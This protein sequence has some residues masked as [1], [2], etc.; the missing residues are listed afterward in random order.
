MPSTSSF[1]RAP[2]DLPESPATQFVLREARRLHRA[3]A[4]QAAFE[5]LPVL[6]RLLA[7]GAAPPAARTLTELFRM[8]GTLQRKHVLR[9]LA[10]EAGHASWEQYRQVLPQLDV[11]ALRQ[12]AE[13][14]RGTGRLKPWFAS[15]AEARRFAAAHGGR[16]VPVGRQAVVLASG[17]GGDMGETGDTAGVSA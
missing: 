12:R 2:R 5:S 9:A 6:R 15:E 10:F 14:E 11:Q 17:H 1:S 16:A 3:A 8:R 4:S 13:A 7:A